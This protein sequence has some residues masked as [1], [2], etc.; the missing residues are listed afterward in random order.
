MRREVTLT[1]LD[2]AL[3]GHLARDPS[4][5]R[6]VRSLGISADRGSYRLRRL[7]RALGAPV[8]AGE[9]GGTE[10]GRTELTSG[11][12]TLLDAG[13]GAVVGSPS[14][15]AAQELVR[16]KGRWV[17]GPVPMVRLDEGLLLAVA[18][19]ARPRER[20]TIAIDPAS[21]LLATREFPTSA[22][23][24]LAGRLTRV[25][26]SGPGTGGGREVAEVNVQGWRV[27]V[28]VTEE[29]VKALGLV[30]GRLVYLYI[31][32]TAVRRQ[33]GPS[34]RGSLRS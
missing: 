28:A 12:R 1:P 30:R 15:E 32:A 6:A 33:P 26:R 23:N 24:V 27:P 20:V 17:E 18:F 19:R 4:L 7:A 25:R 5:A 2:V 11:G 31:K 8:V 13:A 21:I 29:A 9:R 3:L 34:T 10:R 22:R 16:G 14:R